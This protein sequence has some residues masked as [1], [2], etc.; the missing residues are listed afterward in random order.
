MD[1]AEL[2]AAYKAEGGKD[3]G[4]LTIDETVYRTIGST[5]YLK[6]PGVVLVAAPYTNLVA[7]TKFLEGFDFGSYLEDGPIDH[8][9]ELAKFAGQLCYM[10][11]GPKRTMNADAGRY[12]GNILESGHGSVLEHASFSFLLYG[13]SRSMTHELVRHR[14][15]CAYS[16]VSQRY[17]SGKLL[18]FVERPEWQAD[19]HLHASFERRIDLVADEYQRL[20]NQLLSKQEVGDILLSGE[21]ATEKRKK[22][23]QAARACLPN[24]T[25]AP[26]LF[27]A[28]VRAL[29]HC[30]NM[31]AAAPAEVEIRRLFYRIFLLAAMAAPFSFGDAT[32]VDLPDGT[33]A[34]SL[35]NKKV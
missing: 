33:K 34:V 26:I 31:R 15:G 2:K 7:A 25:E 23:N 29:R 28:N 19:A 10:S 18:R 5:A 30:V 20:A 17:V 4:C 27:T 13:I 24:E 11:L 6:G 32:I 12:F 14:A 8:A 3:D 35:A 9:D 16:Q 21:A 22:V 1:L